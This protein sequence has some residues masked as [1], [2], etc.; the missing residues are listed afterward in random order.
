MYECLGFIPHV[1]SVLDQYNARNYLT[2]LMTDDLFPA[3]HIW[4]STVNRLILDRENISFMNE[5]RDERI[6]KIE[7]TLDNPSLLWLAA[8]ND[9]L[10]KSKYAS[11]ARIMT[12]RVFRSGETKCKLCENY[13][14][15]PPLHLIGECV[16][17]ASQRDIFW[18]KITNDCEVNVS[19]ALWQ[20]DDDSFTNV[21]LGMQMEH[22]DFEDHMKIIK[23]AAGIWGNLHKFNQF[24]CLGKFRQQT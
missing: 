17:F 11:L 23:T 9:P 4:K 6:F 8:K 24:M 12:I 20:L 7:R 15:D 3:K 14:D 10:N 1:V 16:A 18:E 22:L 5:F 19:A 2:K 21:V 13:V